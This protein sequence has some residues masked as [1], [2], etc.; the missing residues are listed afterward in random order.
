MKRVVFLNGPPRCGKDTITNQLVSMLPD[1]ENVK[2]SAPLK[3]AL[4]VFF[5]I[6]DEYVEALEQHKE[7]PFSRLLDKTWR[8]VQISL[9][10]TWAKPTFGKEVF[11]QIATN[12]IKASNNSLFFI[13]DS[14][15]PEEANAVV[16]E[17]GRLNCLL[18]RV[19]REGCDFSNDSRSYW[20]NETEIP[21]ISIENNS[22]IDEISRKMYNIII[23]WEYG[24]SI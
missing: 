2:F 7:L 22:S 10:E 18:V 19:I 21:E 4:P 1:S 16:R 14:G 12:K 5:G 11:G 24:D 15:F 20:K 9:S 6:S 3:E 8:E 17:I 13:S 23:G